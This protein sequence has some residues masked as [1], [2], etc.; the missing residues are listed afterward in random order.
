MKLVACTLFENHYHYGVAALAN[1]LYRH[2]YRGNIFAGYK[3]NLPQWASSARENN[4]L[5][6]RGAKILTVEE[7]LKIHFLP[8]VVEYHLTNFKPDF[9]LNLLCGPAKKA[10]SLVYFDP[11]IVLIS[12]WT[13]FEDWLSSCDVCLFEDVNSPL[14][15]NHP[16]RIAWRNYFAIH[17]VSL[18]FKDPSYA[19]GGFIAVRAEKK[20]FLET[21]KRLQNLMAPVIGGLER[22]SVSGV[23]IIKEANTP[24][25]PFGKSDQD[26]LNAA[27]EAWNGKFSFLGK[28]GMAFA[29]GEAI[30]PHALGNPK[31]WRTKFIFQ[32]LKG[33]PPTVAHKAY[34][35]YTKGSISVHSTKTRSLNVFDQRVASLIGRF[36]RRS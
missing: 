32:A 4:D 9:M 20:D 11:D 13:F 30:I 34:W 33:Y 16:K 1:S 25:A 12:P 7:D 18:K 5:E 3:G 15:R 2:G 36:Y 6:W 31:P 35:Q 8:V 24:Y 26:A 17:D 28:E 14:G 23:P 10:E 27:V 29:P 22:S 21:W 19:N